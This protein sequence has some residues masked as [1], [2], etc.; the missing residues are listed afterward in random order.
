[1]S[2]DSIV[3]RNTSASVREVDDNWTVARAR[4]MADLEASLHR[5][6]KALLALDLVAIERQTEEQADLIRKFERLLAEG[7]QAQ[8]SRQQAEKDTRSAAHLWLPGPEEEIRRKA[9]RIAEA[10]R[11]QA[12]LLTRAQC[13]LR[14]LANMLAGSSVIY[15][16]FQNCGQALTADSFSAAG[17]RG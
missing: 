2:T 9:H 6:R 13:K 17:E 3:V 10:T 14:I 5:S 15:G 11:L 4:L 16:P 7:M 12:A 1:M 8:A